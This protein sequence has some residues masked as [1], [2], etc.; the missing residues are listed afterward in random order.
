MS[1]E[2]TQVEASGHDESEVERA[3][4]ARR[5]WWQRALIG[6]GITVAVLVVAAFALYRYGSMAVPSQEVRAEYA[7]L[8][9]AGQAEPIEGRFHI[10][11]PG[12]VCHSDDP[13]LTMQ[14]STRRISECMGCHGGR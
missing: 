4:P 6:I 11:I 9:A 5:P 7:Q 1:D 2:V 13:V 10:P 12:C 8:V 3:C 14:H